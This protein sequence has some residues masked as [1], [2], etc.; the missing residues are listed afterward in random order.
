M[1]G[2]ELGLFVRGERLEKRGDGARWESVGL[3]GKGDLIIKGETLFAA[4][5]P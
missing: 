3:E 5:E 2:R 4:G 1:S